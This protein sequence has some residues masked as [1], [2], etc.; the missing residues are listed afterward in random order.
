[1]LNAL[2]SVARDVLG[3]KTGVPMFVFQLKLIGS[4]TGAA[5]TR[6]P[7]VQEEYTMSVGSRTS[8]FIAAFPATS[9]AS[10]AL[11]AAA[12]E[13]NFPTLSKRLQADKNATLKI[14]KG[15]P[16]GLADTH[17]KTN[18]IPIC[19]HSLR[20]EIALPALYPNIVVKG[21]ASAKGSGYTSGSLEQS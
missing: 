19:K 3:L 1:M 9:V 7:I 12:A 17:I 11:T 21:M 8:R 4:S 14:Y 18:S 6:E 20:A 10:F 16:H 13:E 2:W 5:G 15:A